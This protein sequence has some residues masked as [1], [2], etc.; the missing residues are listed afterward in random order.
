MAQ[1]TENYNLIL[2]GYGDT[3]DIKDINDNTEAID[4]KLKELEDG[5]T[6]T[7]PITRGG[8]GATTQSG[9]RTALGLGTMATLNSP[10]AV[11]KGGTGATTPSSALAALGGASDENVVHITGSETITGSK[12]FSGDF[13]IKGANQYRYAL[14]KNS[15]GNNVT[16]IRSDSGNATNITNSQLAFVEYAPK[17]TPDTGNTGYYESYSLP[18]ATSGISENKGYMILTSKNAVTIPQ[19]G[20]GATTQSG[21]RTALGLGSV[22]TE[23]VLPTTKGGTG[24][25]TPSAARTALGAA[26]STIL[27]ETD[28]SGTNN[29]ISWSAYKSGK[30]VMLKFAT[31]SGGLSTSVSQN[32]SFFTVSSGYRPV[33]LVYFTVR[34][35]TGFQVGTVGTDGTVKMSTS[36]AAS[37]KGFYGTVTYLTA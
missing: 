23:D 35:D 9:A 6:E 28:T 25:T 15:A 8:T 32:T 4:A 12:T 24:A 27:N 33:T 1:Y 36:A 13:S 19:G 2:P 11:N 34:Y 5:V 22:A 30:T 21:A 20:T 37:G 31:G 26:A 17:A 10:L 29:N 14:I 18:A 7:V 16:G 3:A